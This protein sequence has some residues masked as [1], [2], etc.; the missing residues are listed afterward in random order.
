MLVGAASWLHWVAGMAAVPSTTIACGKLN[1]HVSRTKGEC[2][3]GLVVITDWRRPV[4]VLVTI[5]DYRSISGTDRGIPS[6]ATG[7]T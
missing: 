4:Y 6:S 2:H 7:R 3:A 1:Q 5:G